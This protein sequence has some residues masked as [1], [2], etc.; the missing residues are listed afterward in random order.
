L[1]E[2][3]AFIYDSLNQNNQN[4]SSPEYTIESCLGMIVTNQKAC[5][6]SVQN[7]PYSFTTLFKILKI[8]IHKIILPVLY[9]CETWSPS[10][11]RKQLRGIWEWCWGGYLDL[12]QM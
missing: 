6:Y 5:Y 9:S 2:D 1:S 7:I 4:A 11:V 3:L 10:E 8:R 12:L